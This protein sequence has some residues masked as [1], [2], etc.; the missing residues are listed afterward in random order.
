MWS[1]GNQNHR[2]N[3]WG[4]GEIL[5]TDGNANSK[6]CQ[7]QPSPSGSLDR[8]DVTYLMFCKGLGNRAGALKGKCDERM[9]YIL[10]SNYCNRLRSRFHSSLCC[11]NRIARL[12][13]SR[14]ML[15]GVVHLF[16]RM[17]NSGNDSARLAG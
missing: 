3:R 5:Q 15:L 7:L 12:D 17:G 1:G 2:K 16:M 9:A 6:P 4:Y 10:L 13:W 11:G 14:N 8:S